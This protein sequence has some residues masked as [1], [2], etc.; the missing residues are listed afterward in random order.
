MSSICV[1]FTPASVL[2]YV[3]SV[4]AFAAVAPGVQAKLT[5]NA[6]VTRGKAVA[7]VHTV[8]VD[9]EDVLGA[10]SADAA[11]VVVAIDVEFAH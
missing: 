1:F 8:A 2:I 5:F 4:A 6:A 11:V 3:C 9:E 10:K 7:G